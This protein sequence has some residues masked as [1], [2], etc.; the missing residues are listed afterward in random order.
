[1]YKIDLSEQLF[2]IQSFQIR[3]CECNFIQRANSYFDMYEKFL[4]RIMVSQDILRQFQTFSRNIKL[5][6]LEYYAGQHDSSR[7]YFCEAMRSVD[8]QQILACLDDKIFYRAR[9]Q[10]EKARST[11]CTF[12]KDEMFHIAFEKRYRVATQRY[13][14]PGLPCLYLGASV[15]VCCDEL[16]CRDENLNIAVVE[17]WGSKDVWI[18]DLFFF[19][20][21]NFNFLTKQQYD[22]FITLWPLVA[23]CSFVYSETTDM[24][25]RPDYILPQLLL[26]FVIDL[27]AEYGIRG[28]DKEIIG[29]R[30]HSVKKPF[31]NL[32]SETTE[33][34]YVN[35]VFPALTVEESGYCKSLQQHFDVKTVVLLKQIGDTNDI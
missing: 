10:E 14:Y 8:C 26:E 15:A 30:Y 12:S 7:Y 24:N 28:D 2:D 32:A 31:W 22:T 4:Q 25:F 29:I 5:C 13:S 17:K 18:V 21:Y 1:M 27:K 16:N 35:Y 6:L 9:R 34:N 19:K 33:Q 20:N 11:E 3:N 23:C